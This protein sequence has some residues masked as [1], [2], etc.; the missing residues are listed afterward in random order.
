MP[1]EKPPRDPNEKL[2]SEIEKFVELLVELCMHRLKNGYSGDSA[3][4]N[5]EKRP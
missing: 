2:T 5:I 4:K 1:E 3:G